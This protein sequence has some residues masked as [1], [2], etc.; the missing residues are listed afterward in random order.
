MF[1]PHC[2]KE[3]LENQAF[4]Q[5]CGGR[6]TAATSPGTGRRH[7]AW[8]EEGKQWSFGGLMTTLKET[9]F[10]PS[11]FFKK[12]NVTGGLSNPMLYAMITGMVG[13]M[14]YYF[15][16]IIFHDTFLGY[17]PSKAQQGFDLFAETG[18]AVKAILTPFMLIIG[19]FIC[20]GIIHLLL[21]IVRGAKNGFEATFRVIA[22]CSGANLFLLIPLCGAFLSAVWTLVL[23]VI[24]L[25]DAH[26]TSGGKAAFVVL[27][28][29]IM[30]CAFVV[31]FSLLVLG[32]VAA[33]LGTMPQQPWR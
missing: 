24:G 2:G 33:S 3:I 12:M 8:E 10:N 17:L 13:W 7:T 28:P 15:W 11:E 25:R 21:L 29:L 18:L 23:V 19:L 16:E 5:F 1:C 32:T 6:T 22:Y 14:G 9:L 31:L 27:F 4:C 20:S 26:G 30:C